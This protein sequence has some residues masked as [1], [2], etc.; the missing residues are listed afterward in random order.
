MDDMTREAQVARALREY[1]AVEE[2]PDPERIWSGIWR[3][4]PRAKPP[5]VWVALAASFFVGLVA[6]GLISRALSPSV[7]PP[8]T[9]QEASTGDEQ[10]RLHLSRAYALLT[11]V[12]SGVDLVPASVTHQL[13]EE[14]LL[15]NR[16]LQG[17]SATLPSPDA[18]QLLADLEL[19]LTQ[20]ALIGPESN[21]EGALLARDAIFTTTMT[22]RLHAAVA[23]WPAP[24]RLS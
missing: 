16:V 7:A 10:V 1:H 15:E 18:L 19:V 21:P 17:G 3:R 11:V 9:A 4:K 23:R 12:R 8:A 20:V 14:L 22:E 24:G 6:G 2:W 5:R 13:A